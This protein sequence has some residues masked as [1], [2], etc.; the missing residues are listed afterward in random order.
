MAVTDVLVTGGCGFLGNPVVAGLLARG[1][2]VTILD[3]LS[4]GRAPIP[5]PRLQFIKGDI[6]DA[7]LVNEVVSSVPFTHVVHLAALH[8]IPKCDR[9]PKLAFMTNVAGTRNVAQTCV[10]LTALKSFVFAS[11]MAVYTPSSE[12]LDE[13]ALA[14]P[15]DV[16]GWSKLVSEDLVRGACLEGNF[17]GVVLRLS[18]LI[19]PGETNPHLFPELA[20]QIMSGADR[21]EVGNLT[22]KRNYVHTHDVAERVLACLER[23]WNGVEVI[24]IGSEE[25]YSV[26][27]VLTKFQR[28]APHAFE[29]VATQERQRQVD[30]PRLQPNIQKMRRLLGSPSRTVDDAI[31]AIFA[32]E[33]PSFLAA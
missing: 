30:R 20:K 21:I 31:Q 12:V 26:S 13:N 9:E 10:G 8:Y 23:D 5:N 14:V 15:I 17:G 1:A 16:Y 2:N 33:N 29:F 25:E 32:E 24:N 7:R 22:P 4:S 19:G 28:Q 6:A 11:T 18:N 27:E 3:D